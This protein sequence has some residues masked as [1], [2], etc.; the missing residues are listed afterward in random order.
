VYRK[1]AE[2][3]IARLTGAISAMPYPLRS[4]TKGFA[5]TGLLI[6]EQ[7]R[8]PLEGYYE[9]VFASCRGN[10]RNKGSLVLDRFELG[11]HDEVVFAAQ[12]YP[13]FEF[14][15]GRFNVPQPQV[16]RDHQE[17]YLHLDEGE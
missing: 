12:V 2:G 4:V 10:E 11:V 17:V 1:S 13:G 14:E 8:Q 16:L 9:S 7:E 15:R 3:M 5:T 6:K